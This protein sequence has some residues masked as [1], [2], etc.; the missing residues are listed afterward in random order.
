L[1]GSLLQSILEQ[2]SLFNISILQG[3]VA[4]FLRNGGIFNDI[5]IANLPMSLS[6]KEFRELIDC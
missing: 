1:H 2:G 3:S 4:T 5:F 6:L